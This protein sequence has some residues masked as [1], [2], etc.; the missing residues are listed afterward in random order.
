MVGED[1][2]PSDYSLPR[3]V[4]FYSAQPACSPS[5]FRHFGARLKTRSTALQKRLCE[6]E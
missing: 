4:F 6:D 1:Q 5:S 2:T 3:F